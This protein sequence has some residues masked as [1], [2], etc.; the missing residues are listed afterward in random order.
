VSAV[1][2]AITID[3][4]A[5]TLASRDAEDLIRRCYDAF[6]SRDIDA[7]LAGMHADVD[8]P[9][10]VDGGRVR[11]H[12]AVRSYWLRQFEEVDPHVE[13]KALTQDDQGRIVVDVHQVV[14]DLDGNVL[15]EQEVRHVY[16]MRDGL[17]AGMQ[18]EEKID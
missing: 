17:V 18:I 16:S 5:E 13:P 8:W 15:V 9:N 4:V 7:A 14:R 10:A 6:N 2:S 1:A 3:A 12:D 11:G